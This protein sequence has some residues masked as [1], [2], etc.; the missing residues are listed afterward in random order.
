MLNPKGCS[1]GGKRK[2]YGMVVGQAA[3]HREGVLSWQRGK[4]G[5][6][7]RQELS[8]FLGLSGLV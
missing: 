7:A 4:G 6:G 2:M 8:C 3:G 5:V 1:T